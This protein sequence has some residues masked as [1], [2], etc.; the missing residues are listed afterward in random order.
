V[1]FNPV[2][3]L[4]SCTVNIANH[5]S[6]IDTFSYI[7]VMVLTSQLGTKQTVLNFSWDAPNTIT[8]FFTA[9]K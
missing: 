8:H 5:I 7:R 1:K 3:M 2:S 9:I 6:N 4:Y